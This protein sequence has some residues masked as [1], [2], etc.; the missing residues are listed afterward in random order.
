MGP[1]PRIMLLASLLALAPALTA[2][3]NFDPDKLD[4]FGLSQEK[5]LP[6]ERKP[7]FPGG[8]PGVAQGIP[9]EYLKGAQQPPADPSL[10]GPAATDAGNASRTA[11]AEPVEVAKPPPP[12]KPK[13]KP[14]PKARS[15]PK[16]KTASAPPPP[17]PQQP[18]AGQDQQQSNWPEP[19]QQQQAP[20]PVAPAPGTFSR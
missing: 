14:K 11:A 12:A 8:V 15:K 19:N 16:A 1:M 13:P 10:A 5:K 3:S 6:G 20:W 18:A 2:C 4:I 9:P 17:P 7:L